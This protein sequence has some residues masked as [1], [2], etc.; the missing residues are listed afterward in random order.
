MQY[1]QFKQWI[2]REN[3]LPINRKERFYTATVLPSILFHNGLANFFRFLRKIEGFPKD[4][5]QKNTRDN[6]LFYT[7]YNLK[8]SAGKKSVGAGIFTATGDTPDAI[9]EILEP[10]K[11]LVVIEAKM[12]AN[13]TQNDFGKQMAAQKHAVIDVLMNEYC[14]DNAKV[15]HIALTP[16]QLGFK[17]TADYQVIN[18]EFF[19][20]NDD[21]DLQGNYF[22]NFLRFALERYDE[23]VSDQS[24]TASTVED[25]K[26]GFDI[27]KDGT[28]QKE[29]WVGRKGGKLTIEQ[30]VK[31]GT[32]RDKLYCTN[33][34]KPRDGQKGN[35]ISSHEFAEI[36]DQTT[37]GS[38]GIISLTMSP[39]VGPSL[40]QPS[41][42]KWQFPLILKRWYACELIGDFF[43]NRNDFCS[44]S[45]IRIDGVEVSDSEAG[46]FLLRFYH[47]KYQEGVRD[48]LYKLKILEWGNSFMI[49]KS[50]DHTP[51]RILQIYDIDS[52]WISHHL[53]EADVNQDDIQEWLNRHA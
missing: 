22:S 52:A 50:L 43:K 46:V 32:W 2:T 15:F 37:K 3:E 47:A 13:L 24:G 25:E 6:F 7:E 38:A 51:V 42:E 35:W 41:S 5:N 27:Y 40:E 49:A 18:W 23:L 8:E 53:I 10:Q 17:T 21:I 11:V 26:P 33:T 44:Y 45:P 28:S 9:I 19:L 34:Q 31:K 4:I 12:Y 30:D 39:T 36:V 29:L 20:D 14:L 48:K 1:D 16:R